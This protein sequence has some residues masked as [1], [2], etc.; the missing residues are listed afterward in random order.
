MIAQ[1]FGCCLQHT[2]EILDPSDKFRPE[3]DEEQFRDFTANGEY[4]D[5]VQDTYLKMHTNQTTNYVHNRVSTVI[6]RNFAG[7]AKLWEIAMY[8]LDFIQR[9]KSS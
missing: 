3:K 4:F 7:G 1:H 8:Y 6:Y 2:Y 9:A 5:R